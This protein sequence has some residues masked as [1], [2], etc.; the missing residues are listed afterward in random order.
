[1]KLSNDEY[2]KIKLRA[3]VSG[4]SLS[5]FFKETLLKDN[6]VTEKKVREI[7]ASLVKEND[8]K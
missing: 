1:M 4:F 5:G 8:E 3:Q 6:F 7:Y 2:E